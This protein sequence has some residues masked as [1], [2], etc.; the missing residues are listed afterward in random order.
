M[1]SCVGERA[2]A[3]VRR[4]GHLEVYYSQWAGANDR[5]A[6]V[7]DA[8]V[9]SLDSLAAA[10]WQYRGR[11]APAA[12]SGQ[13]DPL[14]I[15]AVYLVSTRG[16]TVYLP[17]WLGFTW[18]REGTP[19]GLFVRIERFAECR[20][21][22]TTVLFLKGVFHEAVGLSVLDCATASDLL[23]LALRVYCGRERIHTPG[24]SL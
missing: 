4:A 3:A 7:L 9:D 22:Q 10:N 1:V 16:L 6:A 23:A 11:L 18:P 8:P 14:A 15:E 13:T 2:L 20:R 5:L 21:L 12:L 17:V 24:A 19:D